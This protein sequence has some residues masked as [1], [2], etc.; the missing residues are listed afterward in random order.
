MVV[1][2]AWP[3]AFK[4]GY[5]LKLSRLKMSNRGGSYS[6]VPG[7][8]FSVQW[9]MNNDFRDI[10]QATGSP[11]I[12][13]ESKS[14]TARF[15]CERI[16]QNSS[17]EISLS[18]SLDVWCACSSSG[19]ARWWGERALIGCMHVLHRSTMVRIENLAGKYFFL[20]F[21]WFYTYELIQ[22]SF[23]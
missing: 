17:G 21:R 10:Q 2:A 9:R 6:D 5:D 19:L 12:V 4:I 1:V 15:S 8:I 3:G 18:Q 14:S 7:D 13:F 23:S 11:T 22:R 16:A 20:C